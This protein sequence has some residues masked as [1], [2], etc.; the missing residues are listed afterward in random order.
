MEV[1]FPHVNLCPLLESHL[2]L[3]AETK[4]LI[5]PDAA[6]VGRGRCAGRGGSLHTVLSGAMPSCFLLVGL[7]PTP[8]PPFFNNKTLDGDPSI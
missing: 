8:P 2:R 7:F 3:C 1:M 6:G 5:T 4:G